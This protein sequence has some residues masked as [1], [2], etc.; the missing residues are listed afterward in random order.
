MFTRM[1]VPTDFSGPSDAALEYARGLAAKLGASL[2][3]LHVI[4]DE[5]AMGA[6]E[7]LTAHPAA[8]RTA[9]LKDAQERLAHRITA[10]DRSRL[11]ARTEVV[12]G[13]SARM[14]VDYAADN[15]FD[16][17]VMGTHGRSGVAHLLMG[18]VAERVI[19]TAP[20]PVVTVR[21]TP[22][23]AHAEARARQEADPEQGCQPPRPV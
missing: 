22:V 21:E 12:F 6:F 17:I 9:M 14:I 19:R 3:V 13:P 10:E 23:V 8:S 11:R 15:G 2:F 4:D 7:L 5:L 1:L 16:L 20:C 18:S